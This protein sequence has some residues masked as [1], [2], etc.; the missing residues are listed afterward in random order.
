MAGECP[1][2]QPLLLVFW[3]REKL[4]CEPEPCVTSADVKK[5]MAASRVEAEEGI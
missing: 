5:M 3:E 1:R 2:L 4:R